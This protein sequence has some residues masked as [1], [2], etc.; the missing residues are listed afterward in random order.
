[1]T[2]QIFNIQKKILLLGCM[3]QAIA[4]TTAAKASD[5]DK[6]AEKFLKTAH[7]IT[8]EKFNYLLAL[9]QQIKDKKIQINAIE[10]ISN[11]DPSNFNW[12]GQNII[13][14]YKYYMEIRSMHKTRHERMTFFKDTLYGLDRQMELYYENKKKDAPARLLKRLLSTQFDKQD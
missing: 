7:E 13:D 5:F 9:E 6:E 14:R 10:A 4:F 12:K 1:M 8:K 2:Q 11:L 3:L